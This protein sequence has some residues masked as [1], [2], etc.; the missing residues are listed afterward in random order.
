MS[1]RSRVLWAFAAIAAIVVAAAV[2]VTATIHTHLVDQLDNRLVAFASAAPS[3]ET[4]QDGSEPPPS[5]DA[6]RPSDVLR[7]YVD[8][9]G[10]LWVI[11][12]P[13]VGETDAVPLITAKQ[14]PSHGSTFFSAPSSGDGAGFRVYARARENY[15]DITA[16]SL[17]EV[18]ATTR[19]LI[20]IQAAAIAAV[21][22]GLA[23]VAVWVV[24]LGVNPMRRMV[25]ASTAIAE[26]ELDV[27]LEGA[28]SGSESAELAASLN[29][30]IENL[31]EAITVRERSQ[32]RLRAFV[33]D[34]SHEL[35]TPLTTVL[36]YAELY[37]K[38]ALTRK[39]EVADAWARTEA[40]ASRMRRLVNDMLDLA[41]YDA[42]PRIMTSSVDLLTLATD[43]AADIRIAHA[44][45]HIAV[46][47]D[48]ALV[49][50]SP[51]GLRQALLNV[52]GNALEHGGAHVDVAVGQ[53]GTLAW[54]VVADDGPGMPPE[55]AARAT[56]RFVR[57]DASRSRAQGGAG[58]GLAITAV[59]VEAHGG[60]VAIE[61]APGAG[62]T[63][64]ISVPVVPSE[65][66]V[67]GP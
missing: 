25:A 27:R 24:R 34:A 10:E 47:G 65:G 14:L 13:N 20:V 61:S 35:R 57:A 64:T 30:M 19:E 43:V 4:S 52:L 66:D 29:A 6:E 28:A 11:Y 53:T 22:A 58:L 7:G 18:Y 67:T 31:T 5:A 9:S 33:A 49:E 26:G 39:A 12:A 42:E 54:I 60:S 16:A 50:A 63:V 32:A 23:L 40:E 2:V 38:G 62:T 48:P 51:D 21:L 41:A 15:I 59:I 55:I 44:D 1:L 17:D 8:T 46:H 56:E 45:A 36:G 3:L 37:R